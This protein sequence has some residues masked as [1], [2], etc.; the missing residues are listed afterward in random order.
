M[1]K[2]NKKVHRRINLNGHYTL[3][4][5]RRPKTKYYTTIKELIDNYQ[6][7]TT[8][9]YNIEASNQYKKRNLINKRRNSI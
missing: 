8:A 7:W 6:D 4:K 5:G 1:P 2:A 9:N 3:V